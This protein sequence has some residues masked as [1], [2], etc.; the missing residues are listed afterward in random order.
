VSTSIALAKRRR[1]GLR[2]KKEASRSG[3]EMKIWGEF[4][5]REDGRELESI[6]GG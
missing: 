3:G 4:E 1:I 2:R 5:R 6:V